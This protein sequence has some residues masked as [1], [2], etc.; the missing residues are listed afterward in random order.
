M[1]SMS[2]QIS[3]YFDGNLSAHEELGLRAWL[4]ESRDHLDQFVVDCFVHTQLI[5]LLSAHQVKA[6]ALV[7][8]ETLPASTGM[9]GIFRA[10]IR[11]LAIAVSI[12]FVVALTYMVVSRPTIVATVTGTG[13]VQWAVG[14]EKRTV[15]SLLQA[16][17][18]LALENG[19]LH[20][21]F[22]GG[23]QV[24]LHGPARFRVDSDASGHLL[25][26]SLSTFVPEHAIGFTIH[27]AKLSVV[28]LGT[29]FY[30]NLKPDQSSELQVFS[31]LVEIRFSEPDN[32][33]DDGKLRISQGRA[34][35]FDAASRDIKAIDYN[36]AMRLPPSDWSK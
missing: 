21:A 22:A 13:G 19:T 7:A 15:G 8:A 33:S 36:T 4:L 27:T 35:R 26:G 6:N 30:I 10:P 2:Q 12:L 29:E 14:G 32:S 31:G 16:G 18:E 23:G 11:I 34:V 3:A 20:V 28:D 1:T 24:A 9:F 5:D 25:S 17:N